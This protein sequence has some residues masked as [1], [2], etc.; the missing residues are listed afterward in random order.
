MPIGDANL[1]FSTKPVNTGQNLAQVA[2]TYIFDNTIDMWQG[3]TA[4]AD[5]APAGVGGP[6]IGDLGRST[7]F[8]VVAEIITTFTSGGAATL[9]LQLFTSD[10][11]AGATNNTVQNATRAHALADL[12]VGKNFSTIK[13]PPGMT[14]RYLGLQAVIAT[15]TTTAGKVIAYL[16]F[17]RQTN[18]N[19]A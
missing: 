12:V 6:L 19:A 1:V 3:K 9:T 8:E 10:D 5:T 4:A 14:Q 15:A 11:A 16:G 13:V 2:G 7:W 17:G 18:I